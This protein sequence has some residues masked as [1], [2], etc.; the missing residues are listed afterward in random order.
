MTDKTAKEWL[1]QYGCVQKGR[2][3]VVL[4]VSNALRALAN[5]M[6]TPLLRC[7]RTGTW[8]FPYTIAIPFMEGQGKAIIRMHN[9]FIQLGQRPI[10]MEK[11]VKGGSVT[12]PFAKS[13]EP[14]A[15]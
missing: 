2:G 8:L 3:K 9:D 10:P 14:A 13:P 15:T 6:G 1:D 5:K 12:A 7:A 4:K 11:A